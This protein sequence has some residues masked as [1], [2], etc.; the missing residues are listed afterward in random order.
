MNLDTVLYATD[1]SPGSGAA[2]EFASA[3][4]KT[5]NA[6]LL[7]VHVDDTTP[8]LVFGDVGYGYVPEV[9]KIADQQYQKLRSVVPTE[10]GIPF[11]HRFV[12]GDA[13]DRIIELAESE[14]VGLIV[15][16]A[17]GQTG[18]I[19]VLLG[20]VAEKVMRRAGCTVLTV[21]L[22]QPTAPSSDEARQS[23]TASAA[24]NK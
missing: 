4:A 5:T 13:A 22:P 9:D 14:Q 16:G 23:G 1:F 3:L 12:R 20:S 2:A 7:I 19:D 8:D 21:N 18:L 11:E 15:L 6:R 24:V 10:E 17:R